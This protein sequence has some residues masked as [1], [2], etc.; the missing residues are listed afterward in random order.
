MK[1]C[2]LNSGLGQLTQAF[3]KLK[4]QWIVAQEEWRDEARGQFEKEHLVEIPAKLQL[5]M[6]AA[7]RLADAIERAE[8]ECGED[9]L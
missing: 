7:Q 5:F 1:Q 8:R 2:D 6:G 9:A 4:E 3:A